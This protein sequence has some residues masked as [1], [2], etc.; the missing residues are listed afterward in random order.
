M[1]KK[2]GEV[3][4][5]KKLVSKAQIEEILKEQA[6]SRK[7]IGEL[8][9]ERQIL[10]QILLYQALAQQHR[11]PFVDLQAVKLNGILIQTVPY[12]IAQEYS[13]IPLEKQDHVLI[14]AVANPRT[15]LPV[16]ELKVLTGT[17]EIQTVL[18]LPDQIEDAL[19]DKYSA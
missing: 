8:L 13:M 16:E 17:Q 7:L 11:M 18:S 5:E 6:H 2:I 14:V 9:V 12:E 1:R 19:R 10:S 3:L 15:S 4:V